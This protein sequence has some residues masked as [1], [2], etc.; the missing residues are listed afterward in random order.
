MPKVVITG[1]V[2][3]SHD[4][5]LRNMAHTKSLGL[6]KVALGQP[7][8]HGRLAVVGGGPSVLNHL[9]EI[10]EC[11]EVWAINGACGFLRAHG[12]DSHL[13]SIDPH[14]IVAKWAVGA[15]KAILCNRTDPEVFEVLK[16]KDVRVYGL[17]NDDPDDVLYTGSSTATA[18]FHMAV[19]SGWMDVCFF[20]CESSFERETH[21]YQDE[22][23]E[24]LMLVEC[25]GQEYLTAPDFYVQA[26]ELSKVMR[27]FRDNFTEQSGGLLR[28]MIENEDHD[29]VK[30]SRA[31]MAGL[32]PIYAESV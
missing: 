17:H 11:A 21:A 10:R 24:H 12:I 1:N 8:R 26:Q 14:P 13:F 30:V 18:A 32:T 19:E 29:V 5:L 27:I 22:K 7:L 28:A 25:G 16:G 20:G 4:T 9:E 23:R 31:M 6:P 3:V 2:P 15:T